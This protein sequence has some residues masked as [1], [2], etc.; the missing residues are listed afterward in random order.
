MSRIETDTPATPSLRRSA[1]NLVC[2]QRPRTSL[3]S[4]AER[5]A[6]AISSSASRQAVLW[7]KPE[8]SNRVAD[9]LVRRNPG[10]VPQI[11]GQRFIEIFDST[12]HR[13]DAHAVVNIVEQLRQATVAFA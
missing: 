7:R 4:D 13:E 3:L 10:N 12:F 6:S 8:F 5:Q 9:D 1:L 2:F 11:E